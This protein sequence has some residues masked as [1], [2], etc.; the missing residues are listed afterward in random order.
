[1]INLIGCTKDHLVL[2][3]TKNSEKREAILNEVLDIEPNNFYALNL[4]AKLYYKQKRYKER[5]E[6]LFKIYVLNPQNVPTLYPVWC[7][8]AG[9]VFTSFSSSSG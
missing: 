7:S 4:L 1:M 2:L 9:K 3:K 6:K 8:G 5:E